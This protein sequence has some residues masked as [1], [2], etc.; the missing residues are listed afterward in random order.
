M[1]ALCD[2]NGAV[3][4]KEIEGVPGLEHHFIS[5]KRE[6]QI[7]QTLGF[8]FIEIKLTEQLVAVTLFEVVN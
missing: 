8:T 4:V 3:R 7:H 5:R 6:V 1:R 2:R